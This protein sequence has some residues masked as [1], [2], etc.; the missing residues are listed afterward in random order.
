M[1]NV[2]AIQPNISGTL[3]ENSVL[4]FLVPCHKLW[5]MAAARVLCSN[6]ANIGERKTWTQNEFSKIPLGGK[7]LSKC[8]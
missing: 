3:S 4:P 1:P 7:S 5:L 6:A 2:I 8:I